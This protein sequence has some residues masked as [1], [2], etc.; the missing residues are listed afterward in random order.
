MANNSNSDRPDHQLNF[1][2]DLIVGAANIALAMAWLK[3]DG[4]PNTRRVYHLAESKKLPIHNIP[5]LGLCIRMSSLEKYLTKLDA[6]FFNE[7]GAL[8]VEQK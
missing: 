5:G 3:A 8:G 2:E 6:P 4:T 1:G 7:Q